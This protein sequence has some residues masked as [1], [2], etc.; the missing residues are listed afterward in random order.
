MGYYPSGC[1]DIPDHSCS[2]CETDEL[3]R[4]RAFAFIQK[5]FVF[6]DPS[7]TAE[8]QAGINSGDIRVVPIS[9]GTVSK[10]SPKTGPGFG[11]VP[12]RLYGYD[13]KASVMDPNLVSNSPFYTAIAGNQNYKFAYVTSSQVWLT[14]MPVLITPNKE[15]KDDL[16]EKICWEIEVDWQIGANQFDE[17]YDIPENIFFE[18]Y[19]AP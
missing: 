15:V 18:C 4:V 11:L 14:Q 12:K 19:I 8:W 5:D 2:I 10:G 6:S 16:L 9:N 7:N 13:L 3:G 17:P 1:N